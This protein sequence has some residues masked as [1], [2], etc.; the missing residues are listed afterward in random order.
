MTEID[1]T[2]LAKRTRQ[3]IM[4]ILDLWSSKEEQLKYQKNVPIAQVSAEL[5]C[6]WADD[7]YH[8]EPT[9]FKMAFDE[10][11]REILADFDKTF[12]DISDKTP[13]ELPYIDDFVKTK[14]WKVVNQAAI[15]A[16]EKIKNVATNNGSNT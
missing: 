9:H 15:N 4:S 16:L 11:E 7:F 1:D 10:K 13:N 8:P 14:E 5:F 3:N 6:Q 2:E 12:N